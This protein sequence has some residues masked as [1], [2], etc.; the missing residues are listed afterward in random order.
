MG[1]KSG[2]GGSSGGVLVVHIDMQTMALDKTWQ[3]IVD[4]EYAVIVQSVGT[5][6]VYQYLA[7]MEKTGDTSYFVNAFMIMGTTI[8]ESNYIA[9]SADGYPVFNQ[10]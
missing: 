1:A 5:T 2:G 10:G 4:A 6:T 8:L 3:E 9:T 7:N